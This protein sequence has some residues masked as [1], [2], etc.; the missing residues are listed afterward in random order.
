VNEKIKMFLGPILIV[1]TFIALF[2]KITV[3]PY[4]IVGGTLFPF[5]RLFL[6]FK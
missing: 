6:P 3:Q 2:A 4:A 1:I 5:N